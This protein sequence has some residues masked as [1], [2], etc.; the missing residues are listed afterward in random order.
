MLFGILI[1]GLLGVIKGFRCSFITPASIFFSVGFTTSGCRILEGAGLLLASIVAVNTTIVTL[2]KTPSITSPVP[3]SATSNLVQ[4]NSFN[5]ANDATRLRSALGNGYLFCS[6]FS[7]ENQDASY[8]ASPSLLAARA[9]L[10]ALDYLFICL[11]TYSLSHSLTDSLTCF[12]TPTPMLPEAKD[13]KD[14]FFGKY[15][16]A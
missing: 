9:V 12:P 8:E 5:T 7:F 2:P 3:P 14:K 10:A 6:C 16:T 15:L 13:L 11:L 1:R 4:V